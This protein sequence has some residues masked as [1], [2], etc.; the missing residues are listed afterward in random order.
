MNTVISLGG[1]VLAADLDPERFRTYG[2][3]VADL[4]ADHR[5]AVVTGG[6]PTAR[7]YIGTAR[8]LGANETDLDALGVAVTRLNARL[9]IAAVGSPAH[10][11]VPTGIDRARE[12]HRTGDVPIM[13]GTVAGHTTD[14]V[15]ASL[16]ESVD[17]DR[18]V[19][20]T[21]VDGVYSGDPNV[22]EDVEKF[23]R[24]D[25]GDLVG[26]IA[27]IDLDA[28]SNAPVDL[29]AAKMIQRSGIETVVCDGSDPAIVRAAA[30]GDAP[31]TVVEP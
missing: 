19:L 17:A 8:E 14:A 9:L 24:I 16:A 25:A 6:G 12:I 21:S 18:L 30:T 13:G 15:A 26:L 22:E 28:G 29:L 31:G 11:T 5:L 2:D 3:L 4:A 10:P 7:E 20:G 23:D 27:E 1:S